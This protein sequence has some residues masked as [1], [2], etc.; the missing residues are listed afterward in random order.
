MLQFLCAAC[1]SAPAQQG[2]V[3]PPD[4]CHHPTTAQTK[5]ITGRKGA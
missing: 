1:A 3:V 4:G 2:A 5:E